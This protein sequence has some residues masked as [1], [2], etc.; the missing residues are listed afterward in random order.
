M[1]GRGGGEQGTRK[2]WNLDLQHLKSCLDD[3]LLFLHQTYYNWIILCSTVVVTA[4]YWE[5]PFNIV[6]FYP[7]WHI[8][9]LLSQVLSVS[10]FLFHLISS[11]TGSR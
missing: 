11:G 1:G 7:Q 8:I 6:I 4:Q 5:K 2:H 9:K 3:S 10:Y